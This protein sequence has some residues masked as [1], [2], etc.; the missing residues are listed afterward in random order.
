MN[1]KMYYYEHT[2][3]PKVFSKTY[4]GHF[5][6][7]ESDLNKMSSIFTNRNQFMIDYHIKDYSRHKSISNWLYTQRNGKFHMFFDHCEIYKTLTGEYI[8]LTSPYSHSE[9]PND[10]ISVYKF[11]EIY[12]LYNDGSKTYLLKLFPSEVKQ[13]KH[14]GRC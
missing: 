6:L 13:L 2:Q 8:I 7:H 3:Y 9:D 12:P 11:T 10:F 14:L 5:S 4:W 1:R